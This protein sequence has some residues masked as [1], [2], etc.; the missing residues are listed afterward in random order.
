AQRQIVSAS[1]HFIAGDPG[2]ARAMLEHTIAALTPGMLQTEALSLLA[3]V[4]IFDGSFLE[5]ARLLER[6][7]AETGENLE[8]RVQMLITLS[9][10]RLNA[11]DLAAA[12]SSI[13][14]AVT[15]AERLGQPQLLSQAL[16]TRAMLRFMRGGGLDGPGLRR[17]LELED[18][19]LDIP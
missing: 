10:A 2:R 17:A 5:A 13:E 1:H 14:D 11:G 15:H 16:G 19:E 9:F 18:P 8:L 6:G 7:L 3:V 4:R 12:A